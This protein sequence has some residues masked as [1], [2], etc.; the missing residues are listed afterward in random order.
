[1]TLDRQE[2][3]FTGGRERRRQFID[4]LQR[5]LEPTVH[6]CPQE[7]SPMDSQSKPRRNVVNCRELRNDQGRTTFWMTFSLEEKRFYALSGIW[8]HVPLIT[9][10]VWSPLHY[11]S[12]HAGYMANLDSQWEFSTWISRASVFLQLDDTGSTGMTIHRRTREEKT[13]YRSVTKV[14][15]AN[16]ASLPPGRITNG[17]T[18]QASAKCSQ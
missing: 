5:S 3:R 14:S 10:R 4:Q 16:S 6:L 11:Q 2:W 12:N 18:V 13:I 8:T 1:M 9:G 17:F 15:R 7:G